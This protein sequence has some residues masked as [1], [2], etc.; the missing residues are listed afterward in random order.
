MVDHCDL[1]RSQTSVNIIWRKKGVPTTCSGRL[2][3]WSLLLSGYQYE[4]K[5]RPGNENANADA[6]SR[7]QIES[8]PEVGT[9]DPPEAVL[10]LHILEMLPQKRITAAQQRKLNRVRHNLNKSEKL[11]VVRLA[12][13][14]Q[15]GDIRALLAP[16]GGTECAGRMCMVRIPSHNTTTG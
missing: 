11:H 6:L 4:L 16:E 15:G 10:A 1:Q 13:N 14:E 12:Q 7:F 8:K 3:R 2:Q 5:Y 9:E